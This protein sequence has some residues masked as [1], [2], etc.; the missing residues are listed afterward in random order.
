MRQSYRM[1]LLIL[2]LIPTSIFAQTYEFSYGYDASGNRTSRTFTLKSASISPKESTS[3]PNELSEAKQEIFEDIV[4]DY[5]IRIYPNPTR[6]MV[7]I[8]IPEFINL[9]AFIL[10]YGIQG[11]LIRS[12]KVKG[13]STRIDLSNQPQGIYILK[14]SIG[15]QSSDWKVI[16]E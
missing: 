12:V 1:V 2:I 13:K 9:S 7:S 15:E 6:G 10:V 11:N 16:K 5:Q 4:S 14:I 8:E 3:I